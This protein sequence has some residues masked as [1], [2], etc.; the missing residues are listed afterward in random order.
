MIIGRMHKT[1]NRNWKQN[2]IRYFACR[3]N[4]L[5]NKQ[6]DEF[7]EKIDFDEKSETPYNLSDKQSICQIFVS[8]VVRSVTTVCKHYII[9]PE[10]RLCV[11]AV[12]SFLISIIWSVLILTRVSIFLFFRNSVI[13]VNSFRSTF[14]PFFSTRVKKWFIFS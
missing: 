5:Q 8:I 11:S 10:F 13:S 7:V 2:L 6:C 9:S 1:R 4:Q 14:F 3:R 12:Y